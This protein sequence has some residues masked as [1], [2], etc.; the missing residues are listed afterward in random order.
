[1]EKYLDRFGWIVAY[2]TV[3]YIGIHIIVA[4]MKY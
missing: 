1:M 4:W 2:F 3:M